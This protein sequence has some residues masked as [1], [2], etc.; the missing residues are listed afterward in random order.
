MWFTEG[1]CYEGD[2]AIGRI[3]M[4][5]AITQYPLPTPYA[6]PGSIAAGPDGGLWFTEGIGQIGRI[7][8]TGVI[9]EYPIPTSNGGPGSITKGP[10]GALWFTESQVNQIGRITTSGAVTEYPITIPGSSYPGSITT[11]PDGALWFTWGINPGGVGRITTSGST[12]GY[13]F[14]L[15]SNPGQIVTGPDNNLWLADGDGNIWQVTTTG[16]FSQYPI[17]IRPSGGGTGTLTLGPDGAMW[18]TVTCNP[19]S[20]DEIGRIT[21]TGLFT[22]FPVPHDGSMGGIATGPDGAL[23]ST[24]TGFFLRIHSTIWRTP[25]C[26]LGLSAR[27]ERELVLVNLDLS[28]GAPATVT[29][30]VGDTTV[31]DQPVH[32]TKQP[33]PYSEEINLASFSGNSYLVKGKMTDSSG[34]LQCAE[35]TT[36][37]P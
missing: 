1:G 8:T 10:D 9:T 4:S 33:L 36:V 35:W 23:W 12:S 37:H 17:P 26:A 3:T 13:S 15:L 27:A 30:V 5:G 24:Q 2:C 14:A 22:E 16:V 25:A 20:N 28:T 32:R 18:F 19:C 29:L 11:G 6:G 7:T 21:T 34:D 31:L